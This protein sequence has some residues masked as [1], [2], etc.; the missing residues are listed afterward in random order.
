MFFKQILSLFPVKMALLVLC[1][2]S[3][4]AQAIYM[5]TSD[6]RDTSVTGKI[7]HFNPKILSL[8]SND[9]SVLISVRYNESLV[10]SEYL[11]N[12]LSEI[13]MSG[14]IAKSSNTCTNLKSNTILEQVELNDSLYLV[15][16]PLMIDNWEITGESAVINEKEV[17]KAVLIENKSTLFDK[18]IF[19]TVVWYSAEEGVRLGPAQYNG[20]PGLVVRVETPMTTYELISFEKKQTKD[21]DCLLEGIILTEEEFKN[22]RLNLQRTKH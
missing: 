9:N 7:E 8:L 19:K 5:V 10:I 2:M 11:E 18:R 12:E 16:K 21:S 13:S 15:E 17:M 22:V 20:F 4:K 14:I 1:S 6:I 3:L